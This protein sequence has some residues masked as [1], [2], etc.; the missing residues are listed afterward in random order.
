MR[1][2]RTRMLVE[3]AL[4]VALSAVLSYT[5]LLQ[6]PYGGTISLAMLPIFVL[7]LRRGVVAGVIAGAL[8]GVVDYFLEPYFVHWIQ[9]LLD[10]PVAHALAGLAG[11]FSPAW[12]KAV[13]E[14]RTARAV[15]TVAMPAMIVGSAARFASHWLSGVVFFKASLGQE[16]PGV[17][18]AIGSVIYN[19]T[20]VLPSLVVCVI[21]AAIVLPA[22]ERAVPSTTVA[23]VGA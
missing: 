17:S 14:H 16:Y 22:L 3:I 5:R 10:Y 11:L 15:W 2:E 21:A 1:N 23:M 13:A 20:Y 12:H 7:A 4:T 9:F 8:F 19:A 6:M 18:Y